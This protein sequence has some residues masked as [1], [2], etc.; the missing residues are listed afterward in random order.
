MTTC[1]T[2]P[3][4]VSTQEALKEL[5]SWLQCDTSV[6]QVHAHRHRCDAV[7]IAIAS[8]ET[9]EKVRALYRSVPDGKY[10]MDPPIARVWMGLYELLKEEPSP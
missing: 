4:A 10:E 5:A 6:L 1:C 8:I 2:N 9:L 3:I 7:R